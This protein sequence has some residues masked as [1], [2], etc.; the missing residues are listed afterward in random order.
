M[1]T[2]LRLT[3]DALRFLLP[4]THLNYRDN[5][6]RWFLAG[7]SRTLIVTASLWLFISSV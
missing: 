1:A 6:N 5:H 3:L 4:L 7:T 2:P